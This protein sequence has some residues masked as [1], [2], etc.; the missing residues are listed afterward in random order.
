MR[1]F[2]I[3]LP[4]LCFFTSCGRNQSDE[5]S[6]RFHDDGRAKPIVAIVPIFDRSGSFIPWNLSEELTSTIEKRLS[7]RAN[8]F[9]MDE[10]RIDTAIAHLNESHHPF[11]KNLEWTQNVFKGNEF[12]VFMELVTHQLTPHENEITIEE[13]KDPT[14]TLDLTMRIRVIDLRSDTPKVILQELITQSHHIPK[15]LSHIDYTKN[16]WGK[17]SY[18]L[19]PYA[20]SHSQFTREISKRL[21]D[22]ILLAKS[23]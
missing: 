12:V 7:R 23:K 21:E 3:A 11:G 22:Y 17:M 18:N 14:L 2:Y 9:L 4:L 6:S 5:I 10:E 8:I 13:K 20:L 15:L 19:T 1:F 16:S